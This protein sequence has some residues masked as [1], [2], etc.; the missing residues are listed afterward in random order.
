MADVWIRLGKNHKYK[1]HG[2]G[3][4]CQVP[5]YDAANMVKKGRARYA[6]DP[7][8]AD[9]TAGGETPGAA[10]GRDVGGDEDEVRYD[11]LK[12]D[13][14]AD[15][16]VQKGLCEDVDT[17]LKFKKAELVSMLQEFDEHNA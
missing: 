7:H 16:A 10:S 12:K 14:L 2:P 5:D 1:E 3:S 8:E 13:Q 11:E 9:P 4:L 15:I 17:A 6:R